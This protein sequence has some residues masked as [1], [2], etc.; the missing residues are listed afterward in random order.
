MR[1]LRLSIFTSLLLVASLAPFAHAQM[2]LMGGGGHSKMFTLGIGGGVAVP[3]SDA[4]D[5]LKNGFNGLAYARAQVPGLPIS[6]GVQVAFQKFDLK[7]GTVTTY[8]GYTG[9]PTTS[10]ASASLLAGLGEVKL[11]LLHGPIQPYVTVGLGA[12]DVHTDLGSD[13]TSASKTRFGLNGG[14][15]LAARI[16]SL[17]AFVQGRVDNVYSSNGGIINA[18]SIQVVPVTVGLEY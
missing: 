16:G 1:K 18:K 12:Y 17:H 13:A 4:K 6:F 11:D 10:T 14:A 5:A 8:S 15:G 9:T 2:G 3:V 7:D